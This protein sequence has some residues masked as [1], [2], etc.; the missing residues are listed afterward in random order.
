MAGRRLIFARIKAGGFMGAFSKRVILLMFPTFL[1]L[2][3]RKRSTLTREEEVDDSELDADL[4]DLLPDDF[5]LPE[6]TTGWI[7]A[8]RSRFRLKLMIKHV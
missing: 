4:A 3:K 5:M 1:K 6:D 8:D 2:R 7:R